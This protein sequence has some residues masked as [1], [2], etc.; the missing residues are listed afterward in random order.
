MD[1]NR[2]CCFIG[3][4]KIEE[5]TELK[6][7]LIK[8]IEDLIL[9]KNVDTFLLGSKSQFNDLCKKALN[10]LKEKYSHI[11]RIYVRAE[12]QYID[13]DYKAYLLKEYDDTYYP[14]QIAVAG[15]AAYV[16]RNYEMKIKAII[17]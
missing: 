16:E 10:E 2:S 11:S 14:E 9:T 8:I 5:T 6:N 12:F 3:H 15:K 17:V 1:K 4:R 7:N 13:D